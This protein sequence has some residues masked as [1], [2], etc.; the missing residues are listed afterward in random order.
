MIKTIAML[1][2]SMLMAASLV[3]DEKHH[4]GA[5]ARSDGEI[6]KVDKDD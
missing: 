5:G 4:K 6:R 3:A 2:T 1:V